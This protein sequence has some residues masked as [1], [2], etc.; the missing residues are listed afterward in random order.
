MEVSTNSIKC[1][2]FNNFDEESIDL[3]TTENECVKDYN[4]SNRIPGK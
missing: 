3:R 2:P 1:L 4:Q